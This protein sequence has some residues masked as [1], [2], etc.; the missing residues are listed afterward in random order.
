MTAPTAL[1][2]DI[3]G[4]HVRFAIVQESG[5]P[6][7]TM[8]MR[9]ADYVG[10]AEAA[11]AY[12]MATR[13][14]ERPRRAAFAVASPISGD[15]IN[16][17][18]SSWSFTIE[19]VREALGLERLEVVN[20]FTAVALAVR[21][22]TPEHLVALGGVAPAPLGPMAVLGPGTGLGVSGLVPARS[23]EWVA[24]AA[25]GGHITMP[26]ADD[27]EAALIAIL[28]RRFGHVSAERVLSGPG[29]VN[30]YE[31]VVGVSGRLPIY[32]TPDAISARALDNS[33]PHCREALDTFF[34]MLGTVA[35]D[36]ALSL[37]ARG[38]VFIA[39]GILPRMKEAFAASGFRARFEAKGRFQDYLAPIPAWLVI[40]PHPAFVGLA[41][42]V[43]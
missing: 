13:P 9:C 37:G 34:V 43:R 11:T 1:I 32:T 5:E 25:E 38:G 21:H 39:G 17:T 22:L 6:L 23:G 20:D 26:A 30:L 24:L 33:C 8:V 3:G 42:L 36:L 16:L 31:A 2:A 40:H 41:G 4:T 12:L 35:G 7:D 14:A 19:A 10:P 28:R 15:R 18:N 27:R 29:L